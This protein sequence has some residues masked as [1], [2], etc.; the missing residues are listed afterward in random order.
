MMNKLIDDI[1]AT[2]QIPKYTLGKLETEIEGCIAHAVFESLAEGTPNTEIDIG[3][4]V[5]YIR[6]EENAVK[7]KFIPSQS[8]EKLINDTIVT[9][10]SPLIERAEYS[11]R[12]RIEAGYK[13]LL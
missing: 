3:I 13:N 12:Q 6:Q 11:L 4:G 5:L 9:K 1:A 10:T 8:F 7:Y 2:T